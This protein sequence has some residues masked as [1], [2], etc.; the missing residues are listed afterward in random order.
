MDMVYL[1][2]VLG[3]VPMICIHT[4]E[5]KDR[6]LY[7]NAQSNRLKYRF[8]YYETELGKNPKESCKLAHLDVIRRHIKKGSRYLMVIEDDCKFIH[9]NP[10]PLADPPSTGWDMLYLGGTVHQRLE[11]YNADWVRIHTWNMH[12]YILNLTNKLLTDEIMKLADAETDDKSPLKGLEIDEYFLK[13]INPRFKCYMTTQMKAIQYNGFSDIEK[14]KVEYSFM[15]DTLNGFRKPLQ[16]QMPDG[17]SS[18][19]KIDFVPP[20]FLPNVSVITIARGAQE[21]S[22]KW[23]PLMMNNFQTS[24]YPKQKLE[25]I[26]IDMNDTLKDLI[27]RDQRIKYFSLLKAAPIG[28]K[29]NYAIEK[30]THDYICFMDDDDYYPPDSIISRV[31]VLMQYEKTGINCVGCTR[32]GVMNWREDKRYIVNEGLIAL[33]ENSLGFRKGFWTKQKFAN[34]DVSHEYKGI[35]KG[36]FSEIMEIPFPL[37]VY[38]IY[39]GNNMTSRYARGIDSKEDFT[40]GFDEDTKMLLEE[41]RKHIMNNEQSVIKK[42]D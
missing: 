10:F 6:R 25:W 30:A 9:G 23:W 22:S 34:S 32:M 31:K 27:P 2:S 12:C 39:H 33:Y 38:A 37:V 8:H 21:H 42:N 35:I 13:Y 11:D 17:K 36:R 41:Q 24:S 7:M 40:E 20:E 19:L 28:Q 26:I 15:E 14:C 29:R 3:D 18:V 4:K 5:R 1:N 16:K